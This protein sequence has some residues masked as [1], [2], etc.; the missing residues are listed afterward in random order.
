MAYDRTGSS[1]TPE[2]SPQL[3]SSRKRE[4]ERLGRQAP[5]PPE[6][7]TLSALHN[8][9]GHSPEA[10][11]SGLVAGPSTRAGPTMLSVPESQSTQLTKPYPCGCERCSLADQERNERRYTVP[12]LHPSRSRAQVS[13][14]TSTL[15]RRWTARRPPSH[16][17]GDVPR[18]DAAASHGSTCPP[19]TDSGHRRAHRL[20]LRRADSVRPR[21]SRNVLAL[22]RQH[23]PIGSEIRCRAVARP[24]LRH[25]FCRTRRCRPET[26][27]ALCQPGRSNRTR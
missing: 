20:L 7:G 2:R 1:A 9:G 21:E 12:L 13:Q 27:P 26:A 16:Q 25:R 22:R 3:S 8:P 15:I 5:E 24:R 10:S 11:G 6:D 4:A 18:I 19:R 17:P 23:E 14:G